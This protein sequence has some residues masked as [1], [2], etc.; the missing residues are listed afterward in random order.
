MPRALTPVRITWLLLLLCY[1]AFWLWYGGNGEPLAPDEIEDFVSRFRESPIGVRDP[2]LAERVRRFAEADDGRELIIVNL[3]KMREGRPRSERGDF[4]LGAPVADP[5]AGVQML[6]KLVSLA[7][8]PVASAEVAESFLQF[9]GAPTWTHIALVRYRSR[10]DFL[11]ATSSHE[12]LEHATRNGAAFRNTIKLAAV[13]RMS[14][15]AGPRALLLAV[16]VG[17][18]AAVHAALRRREA[19]RNQ[20]GT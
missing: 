13:P 9:E 14:F 17:I 5:A 2:K 10:R 12:F 7:G 4:G 16:L 6:R 15:F 18:G 20:A 1:G 19:M 3:V 8:H 11:E